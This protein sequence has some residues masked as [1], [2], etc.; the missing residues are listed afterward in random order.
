MRL[1]LFLIVLACALRA[2]SIPI[3]G[4][5]NDAFPGTDFMQINGPGLSFGIDDA[6]GCLLCGGGPGDC[7]PGTICG[8]NYSK[9]F[10]A[11]ASD[12]DEFLDV[13]YQGISVGLG[14]PGFASAS[15]NLSTTGE[16]YTGQS[17]LTE[18]VTLSGE[19]KASTGSQQFLDL[20]VTGSGTAQLSIGNL[21]FFD[22]PNNVYGID[23][24]FTGTASPSPVPEPKSATLVIL[25]LAGVLAVLKTRCRSRSRLGSLNPPNLV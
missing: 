21:R 24:T 6:V 11:D 13:T 12:L 14:M 4:S 16:L 17:A 20:F 18:P 1:V 9:H 19:I 25:S 8:F 22:D 2:D 7:T 3:T 15:F 10:S 5:I 23:I